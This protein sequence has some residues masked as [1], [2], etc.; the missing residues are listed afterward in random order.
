MEENKDN[1]MGGILSEVQRMLTRGRLD[2]PLTLC[3]AVTRG[4]DLILEQLLKRGLDPN[5]SDSTDH[6]ALVCFIRSLF[7]MMIIRSLL[8]MMITFPSEIY[9]EVTYS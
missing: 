8:F 1:G 7:F 6:T 3:G 5:E 2:L 4:D 9:V